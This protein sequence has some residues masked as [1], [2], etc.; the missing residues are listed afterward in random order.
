MRYFLV[1]PLSMTT[2]FNR[3][4]S[5][6]FVFELWLYNQSILLRCKSSN[7]V[8]QPFSQSNDYVRSVNWFDAL[9][10]GFCFNPLQVFLHFV[11][12]LAEH[13]CLV[14]H[15]KPNLQEASNSPSGILILSN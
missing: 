12:G 3:S 8:V 4:G 7:K 15:V 1:Q 6:P 9:K 2:N 13:I 11:S 14:K 10:H 5:D